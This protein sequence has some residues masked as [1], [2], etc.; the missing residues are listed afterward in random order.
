LKV[1][2]LKKVHLYLA[3]LEGTCPG[4]RIISIDK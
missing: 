1:S 2:N 3:F 4:K